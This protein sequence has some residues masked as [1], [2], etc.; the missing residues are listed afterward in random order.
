MAPQSYEGLPG[1]LSSGALNGS[2]QGNQNLPASVNHPQIL[3]QP[4][5]D[6]QKMV[7]F[8]HRQTRERRESI[9]S[10]KMI[11]FPK[12]THICCPYL[13]HSWLLCLMPILGVMVT[14]KRWFQ[15]LGT[16][17]HLLCHV[18]YFC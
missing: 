14:M 10:S 17:L 8:H 6:R 16:S 3:T 7:N 18:L 12:A 4:S 2:H 9:R 11:F 15:A 13:G 1:V 5:G